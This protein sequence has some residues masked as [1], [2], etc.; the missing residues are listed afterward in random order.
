MQN[1]MFFEMFPLIAF[2]AV[3]YFTKNIFTATLVCIIASWIQ[4]GLYQ[5]IYK[6]IG[7][8]TWISTILI[9]VFGGLTVVLHNK[10]F[11][12]LKPSV[13]FWIIGMSLLIS[14]AMGKNGIR[15]MLQKEINL[16]NKIWNTLNLAWGLFFILMG[17]INLYVA[18]NFSEYVWVKY[19]VFGSLGLTLAFMVITVSLAYILQKRYNT[20][21]YS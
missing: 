19:K 16:P 2:F 9:T 7:K 18:F 20:K 4:L 5:I 11:V 10:T 17:F 1:N 14:Q 8:N 21:N 6:K 12:M 13:L 3:Y 15:L